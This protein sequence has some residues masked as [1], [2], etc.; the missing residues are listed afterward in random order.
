MVDWNSDD[1]FEEKKNILDIVKNT[2]KY[3]VL[4]DDVYQILLL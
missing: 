4:A 2:K 1:S 3:F